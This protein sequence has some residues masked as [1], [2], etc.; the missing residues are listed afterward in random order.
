MIIVQAPLRISF[1]GG[2]TDFPDFFSREGGCVLS[3]TI[4]K[5]VF[6]AIKRRFDDKYRVSYT[7]TEI[8]DSIDQIQHELI[9]ESARRTHLQP[10]VEIITMGDLPA[11]TGLGSSSAVTVGALQAMYAYQGN[12]VTAK[13]LAQLACDIEINVLEKPIGMQD[14]YISA[15]GGFRFIEFAKDG[16]VECRNIALIDDIYRR[17]NESLL[18]FFT[19]KTHVASQVLDEQKKNIDQNSGI[20]RTI[21]DITH[22]AMDEL[23][24]GNLDEFGSILHDTWELKKR[25]A[26]NV[27]NDEIDGWY[28]TALRAGALGGKITGAGGGGCLLLYCPCEKRA[29]V[30]AALSDLRELPFQL[31]PDGSKVILDYRT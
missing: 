9:R 20:L 11:G 17:L 5:Y 4:N 3:T 27:S 18:L 19:G 7:Q 12:F 21:R 25:L 8:V 13:L 31:E 1:F 14:Q 22:V 28:G 15:Y 30:R 2:G 23:E 10:G 26:R 16:T 24:R 29:A 6:I